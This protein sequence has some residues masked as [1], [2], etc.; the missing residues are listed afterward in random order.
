MFLNKRVNIYIL[1]IKYL[2]EYL[3]P[4]SVV[5]L[6][7]IK[8]YLI[9]NS[10]KTKITIF[11]FR[12]YMQ[13]LIGNLALERSS[14]TFSRSGWTSS[15]CQQRKNHWWSWIINCGHIILNLNVPAYNKLQKNLQSTHLDTLGSNY[16]VIRHFAALIQITDKT[17]K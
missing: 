12:Y 13:Q 5:W 3:M 15:I 14:T 9:F 8:R 10:Y 1:L 16:S 6:G 2:S 11:I 7:S 17:T 4:V